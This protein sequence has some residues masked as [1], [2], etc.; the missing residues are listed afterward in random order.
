[1]HIDSFTSQK[2]EILSNLTSNIAFSPKGSVDAPIIELGKIMYNFV[3]CVCYVN[4]IWLHIRFYIVKFLNSLNNYVTTSSCSGRVS[5]YKSNGGTDSSINK[6]IQWLMVSHKLI[7]VSDITRVLDVPNDDPEN[8]NTNT[9]ELKADVIYFKCEGFILHV[10]CRDL[11]SANKLHQLAL[12]CGYKESG[13]TLSAGYAATNPTT[14]TSHGNDKK[15]KSSQKPS[16]STVMLAIRSTAFTFETPIAMCVNHQITPLLLQNHGGTAGGGRYSGLEMIAKEGNHRL[17][18]NFARIDRLLFQLKC[19]LVS[20][21]VMVYGAG[22]EQDQPALV[23]ARW[24]H[25]CVR[26]DCPSSDRDK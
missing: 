2:T 24:G 5:V 20:Y 1:M 21:P 17:R 12:S 18:Q 22:A 9:P 16:K 6:G 23:H 15:R 4:V 10:L 25:S 13:I 3:Y 19:K 8:R 14:T 26:V 11:E 7:A